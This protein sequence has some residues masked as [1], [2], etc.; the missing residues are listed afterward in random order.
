MMRSLILRRLSQLCLLVG[1][2]SSAAVA[3]RTMPGPRVGHALV[4]NEA[5]GAVVLVDGYLSGRAR[6]VP[7]SQPEFTE[8][9]VWKGGRWDMLA[10]SGLRP[11]ARG[12]NS[13][14]YDTQRRLVVSYGGT[15]VGPNARRETETWEWDGRSWRVAAEGGLCSRNH[16][17]AAFD[18]AQSRTVIFGGECSPPTAGLFPSDTW[19]WDGSAWLRKEGD[20]PIGRLSAMAYDARRGVVV[21]HGGV[22]AV[23]TGG[24]PQPE[25]T[26][27]WTWNGAVWRRAAELGPPPRAGHAMTW[28]GVSETVLLYGG[29]TR[30]GELGDMWQWNGA[31]W[32]EVKPPQTNPGPRQGHAMSYDPLRKR[33]ILYGGSACDAGGSA[34]R[35][36]DDTWEWDGTTWTRMK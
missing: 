24:G 18:A 10:D 23:P 5:L 4:F 17:S 27:T 7:G 14:V 25:F 30:D 35:F 6:P 21:L 9:W 19:L 32:T 22:G 28:D 34:C 33:V 20:A 12:G 29:V 36:L 31:R 26:D 3:Q 16:Q 8:L 11:R 2:C 13:V 1:C 15:T